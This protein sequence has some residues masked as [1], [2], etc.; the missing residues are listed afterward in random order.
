[1]IVNRRTLLA[2][3]GLALPALGAQAATSTKKKHARMAKA[4]HKTK[5]TKLSAHHPAKPV[6]PVQG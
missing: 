5:H 2:S 6:T 4:A 1:M 3:L